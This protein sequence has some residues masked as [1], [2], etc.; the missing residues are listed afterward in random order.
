MTKARLF[1]ENINIISSTNCGCYVCIKK[2]I[3]KISNQHAVYTET[4][5]FVKIVSATAAEASTVVK[6]PRTSRGFIA[7][8]RP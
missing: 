1:D 6:S 4:V 8:P 3:R 5:S 7:R 2:K